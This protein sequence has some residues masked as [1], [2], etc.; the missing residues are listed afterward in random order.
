MFPLSTVFSTF[1]SSDSDKQRQKESDAARAAQVLR[2][3]MEENT[4]ARQEETKKRS[5]QEATRTKVHECLKRADQHIK[6]NELEAAYGEIAR[7]K[8]IEPANLYIRAFEERLLQLQGSKHHQQHN[9]TFGDLPMTT[10]VTIPKPS[11]AEA[12]QIAAKVLFQRVDQALAARNL[13]QA[14]EEFKRAREMDPYNLVIPGYQQRL[15]ALERELGRLALQEEQRQRTEEKATA[16]VQKTTL[17][18]RQ[19]EEELTEAEETPPNGSLI[20]AILKLV[21]SLVSAKAWDQ[22]L[23]EVQGGLKVLPENKDLRALEERLLFLKEEDRRSRKIEET[24]QRLTGAPAQEVLTEARDQLNSIAKA[25]TSGITKLIRHIEELVGI[26]AWNEAL[27]EVERAK[28]IDP[29]NSSVSTFEVLISLLKKEQEQHR[30]EFFADHPSLKNEETPDQGSNSRE[31]TTR[32]PA[33]PE[34][35]GA[36]VLAYH[37]SVVNEF[38]HRA[39]E[40][41]LRRAWGD[42]IMSDE[43]RDMLSILRNSFAISENAHARMELEAQWDVYLEAM[44]EAWRNGAITPDDSEH[45]DLLRDRLRI[46]A[47]VH[48][49]LERKIR[50]N[51]LKRGRSALSEI[52]REYDL[53]F[54][55][56]VLG[57]ESRR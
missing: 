51:I 13:V 8:E 7:A 19:Q 34:G 24:K 9:A 43:E 2:M 22:A 4:R 15:D 52:K 16:R 27:Q 17:N 57:T 50:Q 1:I 42:G 56:Q 35:G 49:K 53:L 36:T 47:D 18:K 46:S 6:K 21:G 38:W 30:V 45:L 23:E 44:I 26:K 3:R 29:Q 31:E 10:E 54:R 25:K 33:P 48:L 20:E 39:Y 12:K 40:Q 41:C 11:S 5:E 32:I 55:E 28:Q 14:Q 37:Q